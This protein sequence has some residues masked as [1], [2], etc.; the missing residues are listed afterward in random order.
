MR[1]QLGCQEAAEAAEA[2]VEG[3]EEAEEEVSLYVEVLIEQVLG[4][5]TVSNTLGGPL[6]WTSSGFGGGGGP[7]WGG[8][9]QLGG[10]VCCMRSAC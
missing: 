3:V 6:M 1:S 5:E 4:P 10:V 7:G 8:T 2:A 9:T